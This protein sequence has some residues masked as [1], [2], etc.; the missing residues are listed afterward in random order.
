VSADTGKHERWGEARN[1]SPANGG[2]P[3]SEM[4]FLRIVIPLYLFV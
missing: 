3:K 4:T 1:V 2:E